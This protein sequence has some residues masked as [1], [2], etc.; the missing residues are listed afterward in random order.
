MKD[1]ISACNVR[2]GAGSMEQQ[3]YSALKQRSNVASCF[4]PSTVYFRVKLALSRNASHI[5]EE[6]TGVTDERFCSICL[7]CW[8]GYVIVTY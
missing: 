4:S 1:K 7:M 8:L 3:I 6:Y 2:T 5:S